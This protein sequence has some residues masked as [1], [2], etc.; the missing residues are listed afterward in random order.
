[1]CT[2]VIRVELRL[3]ALFEVGVAHDSLVSIHTSFH[4]KEES[5]CSYSI[6]YRF[7]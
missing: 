3:I 7:S 6:N 4:V 5:G 1:M 2:L